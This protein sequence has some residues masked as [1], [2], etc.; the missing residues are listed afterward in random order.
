MRLSTGTG[1][2]LKTRVSPGL[3]MGKALVK[4]SVLVYLEKL[5]RVAASLRTCPAE[6]TAAAGGSPAPG[7]AGLLPRP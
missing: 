4:S 6:A 2:V 5:S 3:E 7:G 1:F